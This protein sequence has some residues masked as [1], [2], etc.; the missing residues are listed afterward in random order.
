MGR[1]DKAARL[2]AAAALVLAAAASAPLA[3][4]SASAQG[5]QCF[6]AQDW[7]GSSSGGPRELYIRV[8]M[9]DIWRLALAQDCPGAQFPG[10]IS[11]ADLVTGSNEICSGLD[12][13]ISVRPQGSGAGPTACIV[14]SINKLSPEEAKALPKKVVP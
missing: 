6:R 3:V 4:S 10:P 11:I 13:Q 12:L 1:S 9:H 2:A 14:K 5:R 8:G 7:R